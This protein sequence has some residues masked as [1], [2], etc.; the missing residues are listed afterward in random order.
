VS[1]PIE[2][3]FIKDLDLLTSRFMSARSVDQLSGALDSVIN[4][5]FPDVDVTSLFLFST[6]LNHF[7]LVQSRG[8]DDEEKQQLQQNYIR[9]F[10]GEVIRNRKLIKIDDIENYPNN[11]LWSAGK[12]QIK[13]WAYLPITD[14]G[15]IIGVIGVGKSEVDFFNSYKMDLLLFVA[16]LTSLM[17]GNIQLLSRLKHE[18]SML[19]D[20]VDEKTASLQQAFDDLS[21]DSAYKDVFM[22]N[23]SRELLAPL[24]TVMDLSGSI[25]EGIYGPLQEK[26]KSTLLSV[27]NSGQRLLTLINDILDISQ[28]RAGKIKPMPT[29]ISVVDICNT[30]LTDIEKTAQ[31]SG[32]GFNKK[33]G[34]GNES[35][36]CD[37]N[38]IIKIL[39]VLFDSALE[40]TPAGGAIETDL[41]LDGDR[42]LITISGIKSALVTDRHKEDP[43]SL[44]EFENYL[45]NKQHDSGLGL[46]L[47]KQLAE[48]NGGGIALES[49][50]SLKTSFVLTL[51]EKKASEKSI[52][53][54]SRQ[55]RVAYRVLYAEDNPLNIKTVT[56]YLEAHGMTVVSA[57]NGELAVELAES[58]RPD[59]VLMDIQMPRMDGLEATRKIKKIVG[60]EHVPVVALT[61]FATDEDR[62]ACINAGCSEFLSKPVS[63][64]NLIRTIQDLLN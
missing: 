59:I 45:S 56:E 51:P 47:A 21:R 32:V 1:S 2:S 33:F 17:F 22:E 10:T 27:H 39:T 43:S 15:K 3:G 9:C 62:T 19:A 23:M 40:V 18:H 61:A 25:L 30:V 8:L 41:K 13:S 20:R 26:Q 36:W 38:H 16:R 28:I 34:A 53:P 11:D 12:H 57:V 49:D 24:D 55:H 42:T 52:N 14:G 50:D 31:D 6:H 46:S 37:S 48:L 35:V 4:D 64:K 60:M 29:S 7:R 63:L 44:G 58:I 5:F 54:V